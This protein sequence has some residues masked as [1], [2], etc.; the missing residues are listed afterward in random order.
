MYLSV[1]S[2]TCSMKISV[3]CASHALIS[4]R[5]PVPTAHTMYKHDRCVPSHGLKCS[6]LNYSIY[7]PSRCLSCSLLLCYESME[8][9]QSRIGS[10]GPQ[11]NFRLKIG[12]MLK[13][14]RYTSEK[15]SL[16]F[17]RSVIEIS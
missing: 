15:A 6:G 2:T 5:C 13:K 14:K 3:R 4:C 9:K 10:Q 11:L 7:Y 12:T 16:G 17:S 8:K 1:V